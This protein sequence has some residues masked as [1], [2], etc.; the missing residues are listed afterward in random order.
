QITDKPVVATI[1]TDTH[2]D[3]VGGNLEFPANVEVV[4]QEHTAKL[5]QEMRPVTGV[6]APMPNLSKESGGRGLPTRTFTDRMT[7]GSGS[8]RIDLY[9]FGRAHTSG[10][11]WVVFPALRV[12]HAGDAFAG[13]GVPPLDANNG[14]SGVEYPQTIARALV[15]LTNID[16]V[17]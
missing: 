15:T 3:H 13:K 1:N 12:L 2:V 17:I 5:M 6:P 10:D 8:D 11:A 7:I 16:T 14:A 4:A 9:Y